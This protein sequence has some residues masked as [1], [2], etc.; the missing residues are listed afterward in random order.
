MKVAIIGCGVMGSAM[1]RVMAKK[2]VQLH[3][4]DHHTEKGKALAAELKGTFYTEAKD[5]VAGVD[6]ILLAIKPKDLAFGAAQMGKLDGKIVLSILAGTDLKVLKKEL[7]SATV[8]RCMLNL[9]LTVGEGVIALAKDPTL[10]QKTIEQVG[11]L[12]SGMGLVLWTEEAKLDPITALSGSGI[13]FVLAIIESFVE[14]G[15]AMGLRADEA[16]ELVLQTLLGAVSMTKA[17]PGHPG[18]LRWQI[19]AP[20]GT[21]I[22]GMRAFETSGVRAGIMHTLLATFDKARAMH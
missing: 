13:A 1:A 20:A 10:S 14:G 18:E 12:L 15:V 8:I 2:G 22:A 21:T 9:A 5:A 11:H 6:A 4:C 3:L 19:S 17:H 7:P 16:K